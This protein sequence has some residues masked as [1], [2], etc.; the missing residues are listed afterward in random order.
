MIVDPLALA[1]NPFKFESESFRDSA[2]SSVLE[3]APDLNA[4]QVQPV[5]AMS[6]S[7]VHALD[8]SPFP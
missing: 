2:T 8:I 4:V 7:A 1:Q 5:N 3:G 6:T